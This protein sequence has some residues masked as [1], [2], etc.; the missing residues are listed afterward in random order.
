MCG[1]DR[2]IDGYPDHKLQCTEI[3]CA[4]DNCPDVSN[5]GQEDADGDGI[6]DSCDL[7]ADGDGIPNVP[8]TYQ[9]LL[10][11]YNL[12]KK[13]FDIL[14]KILSFAVCMG[15]KVA[16]PH[17]QGFWRISDFQIRR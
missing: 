16:S 15:N 3:Q 9:K 11:I 2:D 12:K 4:A 14:L 1:P 13:T 17:Y 8:V 10:D 5:S 7:D 6:G